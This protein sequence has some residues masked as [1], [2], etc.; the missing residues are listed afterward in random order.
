MGPWSPSPFFPLGISGV[1]GVARLRDAPFFFFFEHLGAK[2]CGRYRQ[3]STPSPFPMVVDP[4]SSSVSSFR[5]FPHLWIFSSLRW[6]CTF[7]HPS[8][9]PPFIGMTQL[10]IVLLFPPPFFPSDSRALDFLLYSRSRKGAAML[11]FS[12]SFFPRALAAR[13]RFL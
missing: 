12:V 1:E 6:P 7:F 9:A 2:V 8:P 3:L 11:E 13:R 4:V 10:N 5:S